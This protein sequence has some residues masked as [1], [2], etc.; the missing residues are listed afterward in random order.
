[1]EVSNLKL[2]ANYMDCQLTSSALHG[3]GKVHSMFHSSV[4]IL[5]ENGCFCTLCAPADD[6]GPNGIILEKSICF[7][8]P[9]LHLSQG[10]LV[11]IHKG[12]LLLGEIC[13]ET[14]NAETF[15][16]KL[17][18]LSPGLTPQQISL[19]KAKALSAKE[20]ISIQRKDWD[21][22]AQFQKRTEQFCS[23]ITLNWRTVPH[24]VKQLIGFGIG[25]TPSGDDFLT[26]CLSVL[27]V[28]LGAKAP[29]LHTIHRAI[30]RNIGRTTTI[31][32]YMLLQACSGQV[33]CSLKNWILS[34]YQEDSENEAVCRHQLLR[35][36]ATSG[37]DMAAGVIEG[38]RII[39]INQ[40]KNYN[41]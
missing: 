12:N 5:L 26:G 25:S 41:L 2:Q 18:D 33:M 24:S 3:R 11:T 35:I 6:Y 39:W 23:A 15:S 19:G 9:S 37:Y 38:C 1:M 27:T 7:L 14:R 29:Q 34:L 40:H 21:W 10:Q 4:N 32:K 8:E 31:S 17:P 30:Q 22:P 20:S 28:C 13:V 36:G 16:C